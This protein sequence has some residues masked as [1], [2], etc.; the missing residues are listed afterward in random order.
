VGWDVK[1]QLFVTVII[2]IDCSSS[3]VCGVNK[4][5]CSQSDRTYVS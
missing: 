5:Q 2:F 3:S 4:Q 1:I